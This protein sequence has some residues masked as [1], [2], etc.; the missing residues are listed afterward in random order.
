MQE[1]WIQ[2]LGAQAGSCT[3]PDR[4]L[5]QGRGKA[6]RRATHRTSPI[7]TKH[8]ECC[9]HDDVP[10]CR[11]SPCAGARRRARAGLV[12]TTVQQL[13]FPRLRGGRGGGAPPPPNYVVGTGHTGSS[14][15]FRNGAEL[16]EIALPVG[17]R[18]KTALAPKEI[19]GTL[20]VNATCEFGPEP[21]ARPDMDVHACFMDF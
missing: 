11:D 17:R 14:A 10:R 21:F 6:L 1:T 19:Y 2:V 12:S 4:R 9:H 5:I 15:S 16:A 13:R 7:V 20:R 8:G 18:A 3:R